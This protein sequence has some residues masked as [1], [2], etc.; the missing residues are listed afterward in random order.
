MAWEQAGGLYS[1]GES[2]DFELFYWTN[3]ILSNPVAKVRNT[4]SAA[5][6]SRGKNLEYR[7]MFI[8]QKK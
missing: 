7:A 8:F 4:F 2:S 3:G 1:H 6:D 5:K